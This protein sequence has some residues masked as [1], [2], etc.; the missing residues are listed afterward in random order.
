MEILTH[1]WYSLVLLIT[2]AFFGLTIDLLFRGPMSRGRDRLLDWRAA[3]SIRG[4]E[5]RIRGAKEVG[6]RC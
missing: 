4:L 2:G 1:A 5:R 6:S 3:R